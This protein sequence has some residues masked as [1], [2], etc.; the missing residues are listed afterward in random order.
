MSWWKFEVWTPLGGLSLSV[1]NSCLVRC[2]NQSNTWV[3]SA[4]ESGSLGL[5]AEGVGWEKDVWTRRRK[6][7][8]EADARCLAVFDS[9]WPHGLYP[10]RLPCPW[11]LPGKD[12]WGGLPFPSPE[13]LPN[14]EIKPASLTSPALV[15][16]F[17]TTSTTCEAH[18]SQGM[19]TRRWIPGDGYL[20]ILLLKGTASSCLRLSCLLLCWEL[21]VGL[22]QMLSLFSNGA[23]LHLNLGSV[24]A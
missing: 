11:N 22:I 16:R 12:N 8:K 4:S 6:E 7:R 14:P 9:L 5:G 2:L 1:T 3:M 21:Y 20:G 17:F 10:A 24:L 15:G 23:H 18:E 19:G 13:D